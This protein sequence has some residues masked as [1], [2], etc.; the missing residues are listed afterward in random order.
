MDFEVKIT[1]FERKCLRC[2]IHIWVPY[3]LNPSGTVTEKYID[4][5]FRN[6]FM[7][8]EFSILFSELFQMEHDIGAK[9]HPSSVYFV[10]LK[11]VW[12]LYV[13]ISCI[14]PGSL[15]AD[16][17]MRSHCSLFSHSSAGFRCTLQ[18]EVWDEKHIGCFETKSNPSSFI[19]IRPD[20][21]A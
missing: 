17:P 9:L 14:W 15:I 12:S 13:S 18:F 11:M 20:M 1:M 10:G 5:T 2:E 3:Q 19:Q 7:V 21:S 8:H 4:S 6:L 16:G